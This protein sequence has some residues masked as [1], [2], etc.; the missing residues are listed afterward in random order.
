ML[1]LTNE[2]MVFKEV[3]NKHFTSLESYFSK[4]LGE[5][6]EMM[7]RGNNP[8]DIGDIDALQDYI[9]K[10]KE[11]NIVKVKEMLTNHVNLA[12]HIS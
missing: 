12:S 4:K 3:R 1:L 6:S 11:M 10:L 9:S 2:D 7:K 5:I 8:S